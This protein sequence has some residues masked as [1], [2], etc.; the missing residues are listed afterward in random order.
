MKTQ[1]QSAELVALEDT[2]LEAVAGGRGSKHDKDRDGGAKVKLAE[3]FNEQYN[4]VT[5]DN[6]D[7]AVNGAF[8][9]TQSN[10]ATNTIDQSS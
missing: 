10:T 6:S 1:I 9:I 8:N 4:D 2:T 3:L 7:V 5:I